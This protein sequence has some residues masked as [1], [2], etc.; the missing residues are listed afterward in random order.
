MPQCN[1]SLTARVEDQ[2]RS[3]HC[4]AADDFG[5][6]TIEADQVANAGEGRRG[7]RV[8]RARRVARWTAPQRG[9]RQVSRLSFFRTQKEA[10]LV[11]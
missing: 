5:E 2:R 6:V 9:T 8:I 1:S 3:S 11:P 10:H 4:Q 7:G